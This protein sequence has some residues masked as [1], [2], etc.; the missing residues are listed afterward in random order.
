MQ[1][2][3]ASGRTPI[4]MPHR[5]ASGTVKCRCCKTRIS[6]LYHCRRN[7]A[8]QQCGCEL[9]QK[10]SPV[11]PATDNSQ[12]PCVMDFPL[13]NLLNSALDEE[14]NEWDPDWRVFTITLVRLQCMQIPIICLLFLITEHSALCRRVERPAS[15]SFSSGSH[16]AAHLAWHSAGVLW[17][18]TGYAVG[19]DRG[20]GALRQNFSGQTSGGDAVNAFTHHRLT[21]LMQQ[22]FDFT[23]KCCVGVGA[24]R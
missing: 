5:K 22:T 15:A 6:A 20:D 23:R 14:T 3:M 21:P 19:K 12:L 9:L 2:L 10:D 4:P 13:M 18:R 16:F 7:L 17:R 24:T 8:Q 11:A 1:V